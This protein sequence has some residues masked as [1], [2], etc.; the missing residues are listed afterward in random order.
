MPSEKKL[1]PKSVRINAGRDHFV[2]FLCDH[3]LIVRIRHTEPLGG[4][5]QHTDVAEPVAQHLRDRMGQILL[6]LGKIRRRIVHKA[7]ETVTYVG[8]DLGCKPEEIH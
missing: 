4:G 2:N 1:F 8:Q 3:G 6:S 5:I 7:Q